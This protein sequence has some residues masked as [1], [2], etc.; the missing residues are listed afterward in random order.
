TSADARRLAALSLTAPDL[1]TSLLLAAAAYRLL[2]SDDTSGALLSAL[3]RSGTALWRLPLPGPA[4]FVAIDESNHDL[5]TMDNTHTVHRFD[6]DSRRV[7]TSFPARA[8]QTVGLS[9]DSRQLVV[10]GRSYYFDTAGDA[11][12]SVLD[13]SDGSTVSVLPVHTVA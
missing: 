7:V 2:P 4:E 5:W 8:D 9:P 3:Q 6:L 10:A 11:R 1:R 13:A 12:I